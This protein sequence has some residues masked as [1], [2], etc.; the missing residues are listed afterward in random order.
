MPSA[1][2]SAR[3]TVLNRSKVLASRSA[4]H[5]K[6]HRVSRSISVPHATLAAPF[7][8][9]PYFP[10]C[11][12]APPPSPLPSLLTAVCSV[13]RLVMPALLLLPD[14]PLFNVWEHLLGDLPAHVSFSQTCRRFRELYGK[15]DAKWQAALFCA[16]FGLPLRQMATARATGGMDGLTWRRLACLLV[17]HTTVCEIGSCM[18]ANACFGESLFHRHSPPSAIVF[19]YIRH[20]AQSCL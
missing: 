13:T 17:G 8:F 5:T 6:T 20:A 11:L 2:T 10:H 19:P 18:R 3:C 9:A 15:D 4:Q 14:P 12:S 7:L 16:G 1:S